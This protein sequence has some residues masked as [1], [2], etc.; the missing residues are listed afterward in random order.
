MKA[1]ELDDSL[2]IQAECKRSVR[3]AAAVIVATR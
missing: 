2:G 3:F 1:L